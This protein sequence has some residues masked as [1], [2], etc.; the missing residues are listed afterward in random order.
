MSYYA[1]DGENLLEGSSCSLTK[2]Q[3]L[4]EAIDLNEDWSLLETKQDKDQ[5]TSEIINEA[6]ICE[7]MCDGVPSRNTLGIQYRERVVIMVKNGNND[8]PE[9]L[10]LRQSFPVVEHLNA[11]LEGA[12]KS[13]CLYF[14]PQESVNRTWTAQK[15][16]RRVQWWLESTAKGTLHAADQP[17]EQLFFDSPW[18]LVLPHDALDPSVEDARVLY[19]DSVVERSGSSMTYKAG[20]NKPDN[21]APK[22]KLIDIKCPPVVSSSISVLPFSFSTLVEVL[23]DKGIDFE[24]FFS[25]AIKEAVGSGKPAITENFPT[26]ILVQMPINRASGE[27]VEKIQYTAFLSKL[28]Y[29]EIGE[30]RNHITRLEDKYFDYALVGEQSAEPPED[31]DLTPVTVL[32]E[33]SAKE[34]RLQSGIV[35]EELNGVVVGVGALGSA[36]VNLFYRSGW[37]S[38]EIIDKDHIKPHNL[39]R[40]IALKH[41]IG[42]TKVQ[43]VFELCGAS[44]DNED[45]LSGVVEDALNLDNELIERAFANKKIVIDVSTSLDYPR[46]VSTSDNIPRHVSVFITPNGESCV[47][48]A[49]DESRNIRL[50]T[51]EAQ[52]YHAVINNNWGDDHISGHL[53]SYWAGGSCRD[54]SHVLSLSKVTSHAA[55][56]SD[57]IRL[58]GDNAKAAVWKESPESG[59]RTFQEISLSPCVQYQIDEYTVSLNEELVRKLC[60]I[61]SA[62][63]PSETGGVLVGYHDFNVNSVVIVDALPAPKDSESSATSFKR[64]VDSLSKKV[65]DIRER[66]AGI[67]DYIGEWHSHPDGCSSMPSDHDLFQLAALAEKMKLDGLPAYSLIVGENDIR[68]LKGSV[69][70]I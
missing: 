15:H 54:I 32:F 56:L 69:Q 28:N 43:A 59:E 18:E 11:T 37:G 53:G 31:F 36:M 49:E 25:S 60:E 12:P 55:L 24:G 5:N 44:F 70:N 1:I 30:K 48:L 46:L 42:F 21:E 40:H 68:I 52:Y 4:V 45:N 8:I 16:L 41:Q 51:I 33:S 66:T 14:E 35:E 7:V 9:V 13:L 6:L 23:S 22:V 34:R 58:L 20:W 63:L 38:W 3:Q 27:P 62:N 26:I 57:Q 67:V 64:G 47:L 61:R 17:V 39:V 10:A 19:V 50:S 65:S 29:L 2:A